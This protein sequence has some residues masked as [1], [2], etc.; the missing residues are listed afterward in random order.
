MT[1]ILLFVVVYAS[2]R[3][4]IVLAGEAVRDAERTNGLQVNGSNVDVK[5]GAPGERRAGAG[6]V[7]GPRR[8]N[9]K[10]RTAAEALASAAEAAA[11]EAAAAEAAE[12]AGAAWGSTAFRAISRPFLIGRALDG[13]LLPTVR[14]AERVRKARRHPQCPTASRLSN[15]VGRGV[16]RQ[17]ET[18]RP[19]GS[20]MQEVGEQLF[21]DL[22]LVDGDDV[23]SVVNDLDARLGQL[24]AETGCHLRP[25][26]EPFVSA[27][28]DE[29]RNPGG[30]KRPQVAACRSNVPDKRDFEA[31]H[32]NNEL[33]HDQLPRGVPQPPTARW[34][35]TSLDEQLEARLATVE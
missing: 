9:W 22:G 28:D 30:R 7:S 23:I 12:R 11:A 2:D 35:N 20:L 32:A 4:G 8:S 5:R 29:H 17:S 16:R 27:D 24:L 1:T 6:Q 33:L 31:H 19:P 34:S 10:G 25:I 18:A 26:V 15:G 13:P 14:A 21:H 3:R